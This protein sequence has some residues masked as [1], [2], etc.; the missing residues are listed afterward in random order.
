[1]FELNLLRPAVRFLESLK[2]DADRNEV[3]R[4]LDIIAV[5]PFWDQR[6]KFPFPVPPAIVSMYRS[7]RFKI[8]YHVINSSRINVW[9]IG[10]AEDKP[11]IR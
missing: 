7:D 4:L 9:A 5:D 3:R 8:V 11:Q 1:L 10:F 2:E 6:T